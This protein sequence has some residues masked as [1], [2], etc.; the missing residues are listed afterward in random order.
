MESVSLFVKCRHCGKDIPK[1]E[2]ICP[3]CGN[4]QKKLTRM[5]W[6]GIAFAVLL[7]I[8]MLN[9]G[10]TSD[11]SKS[12]NTAMPTSLHASVASKE[13]TQNNEVKQEDQK[14]FIAIINKY[15]EKFSATKNELQQ[16][17]LR[18]ERKYELRS[19]NIQYNILNWTGY[20][21]SLETNFDGNAIISIRID[22]NIAENTFN[23]AF[24][25]I[26]FGTIINKNSQL[27]LQ[28]S[29][30]SRG[31]KVLFSG[32]FFP[33]DDDNFFE[34]SVTISGSMRKPEFIFGFSAIHQIN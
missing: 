7:V 32:T 29:K 30:L 17:M 12:A 23:N 16:Y 6:I 3:Q 28:L 13:Q 22:K 34:S 9:S 31:Q 20:I 8:G 14:K 21:D 11:K 1:I 15:M 33:S 27:Y 18:E 26:H 19:S 10:G 5:H 25:D 2:K 4:R 24:T